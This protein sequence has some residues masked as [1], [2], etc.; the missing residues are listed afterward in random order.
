MKA[1]IALAAAALMLGG[2]VDTYLDQKG[3]LM[4]GQTQARVMG[5][6]IQYNQA[7]A[8]N[9]QLKAQQQDIEDKLVSTRRDIDRLEQR[10][11]ALMAN[12]KTARTALDQARQQNKISQAQ[13]DQGKQQLDQLN[14]DARSLDLQLKAGDV[15]G[16]ADAAK[17]QQ[18]IADL[19]KKRAE[20]EQALKL[21]TGN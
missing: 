2:C 14:R 10:N 20:L 11:A 9:D 19:E 16:D 18:Q 12:L 8:Q 17:K 1:A 21:S 7:K 13:Y 4:S 5:A 15:N 3:Q 6:Q